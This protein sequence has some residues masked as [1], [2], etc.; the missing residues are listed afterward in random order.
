MSSNHDNRRIKSASKVAVL[1][2]RLRRCVG[3]DDYVAVLRALVATPAPAAIPVLASLLDSTGP[4][5]EHSIA[6]LLTFR[7]PAVPAMRE[8]VDSLDYDMIRHGHRVL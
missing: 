5:A 7:E 2:R 8:C 4:I 3:S 6:G 1:T